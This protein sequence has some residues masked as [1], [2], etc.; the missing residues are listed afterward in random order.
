MS[1]SLPVLD[2]WDDQ[3]P[4][5]P[6]E[7]ALDEPPGLLAA[8]GSLRPGRLLAA[9]RRGIF[10]WYGAGDPVLWWTPDPRCVIFP[11]RLHVSRRLRRKLRQVPLTVTRDTAFGAVV[12]GCAAPRA[13]EG[14]TWIL[15]EMRVAYERMH[16]LGHATSFEC[17]QRGRLVGGIYGIHLGRVFFGESMFSRVSDASKIALHSAACADDID[18]IDCQLPTAHLERLGAELIPRQRFL[19]LLDALGAGTA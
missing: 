8:G 15:P 10:P 19:A 12:A 18:L 11:E 14:G 5:P 1:I 2:P 7:Q 9:Y 4:F 13:G 16:A 17:W 3:T 6:P